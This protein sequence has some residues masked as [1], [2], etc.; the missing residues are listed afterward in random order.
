MLVEE[1]ISML[2]EATIRKDS[3]STTILMTDKSRRSVRESM[4]GS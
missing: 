3:P 4:I 1:H 2:N